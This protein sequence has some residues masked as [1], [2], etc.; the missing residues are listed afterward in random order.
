MMDAY[1]YGPKLFISSK[2]GMILTMWKKV[3]M[4]NM[5]RNHLI[6]GQ[7]GKPLTDARETTNN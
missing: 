1:K 6:I 3:L 7:C 2:Q 5:E 4:L